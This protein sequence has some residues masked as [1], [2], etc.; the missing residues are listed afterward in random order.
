MKRVKGLKGKKILSGQISTGVKHK[1]QLFDGKYTTG[2]RV[3][4]VAI[5]PDF[6]STGEEFVGKLHTQQ[7]TTMGS[8]DFG[9]VE[10][11]AWMTWGVPLPSRFSEYELI[12]GDNMVLE[13]LYISVYTT[14]EAGLIN[15]YIELDKYEFS[16]WDGAAT[17]VRNQSQAGPV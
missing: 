11:I 14:G 17:M 2:Y 7:S 4:K 10:Q 5:A 8:W 6:P 15:Y 3:S 9:D 16:A 1:L 13:D 12:R